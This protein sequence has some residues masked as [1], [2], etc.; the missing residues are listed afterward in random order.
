MLLQTGEF[1]MVSK[2][3]DR[4]PATDAA[5]LHAL[6]RG[7]RVLTWSG[8]ELVELTV[9]EQERLIETPRPDSVRPACPAWR[10][11]LEAFWRVTLGR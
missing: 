10:R 5:A 1:V 9:D 11:C 4:T 7:E 8:G 2:P 3:L 6:G